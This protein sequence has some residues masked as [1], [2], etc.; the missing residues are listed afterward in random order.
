LSPIGDIL[1]RTARRSPGSQARTR[2]GQLRTGPDA[3]DSPDSRVKVNGHEIANQ[4]FIRFGVCSFQGL[5]PQESLPEFVA[6]GGAEAMFPSL[7]T[8]PTDQKEEKIH[9][10]SYGPC[11][12]AR[13]E[14]TGPGRPGHSRRWVGHRSDSTGA[15]R[16][17]L[18]S[19]S[20][21]EQRFVKFVRASWRSPVQSRRECPLARSGDL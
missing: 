9:R 8:L 3:P 13:T 18:D 11:G 4:T 6:S 17:I 16:I 20:T 19:A 12:I 5:K 1:G 14:K 10:K 2:P 7:P 15:Q 21:A